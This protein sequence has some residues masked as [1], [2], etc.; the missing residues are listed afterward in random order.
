M[1]IP[2]SSIV[3]SSVDHVVVV[4]SIKAIHFSNKTSSHQEAHLSA[5]LAMACNKHTHTIRMHMSH[6]ICKIQTYVLVIWMHFTLRYKLSPWLCFM[7]HTQSRSNVTYTPHANNS[8]LCVTWPWISSGHAWYSKRIK[9]L[10]HLGNIY[11]YL[12]HMICLCPSQFYTS[13]RKKVEKDKKGE[14]FQIDMSPQCSF[15]FGPS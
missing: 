9:I 10:R 14:R 11:I 7:G 13:A 8:S 5:G 6:H 12:Q 15:P 2:R 3:G 1:Y 4:E